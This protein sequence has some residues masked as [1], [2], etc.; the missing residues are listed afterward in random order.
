M[1][2]RLA[3]AEDQQRTTNHA[4][5]TTTLAALKRAEE[6][7]NKGD[8]DA[9]VSQAEKAAAVD[10][11]LAAPLLQK[12]S[13]DLKTMGWDALITADHHTAIN[14]L[15]QA[16][17]LNPADQNA[18]TKLDQARDYAAKW[19]LVETKIKEFDALMAQKDLVAHQVLI[20]AQN[21]ADNHGPGDSQQATPDMKRVRNDFDQGV[22]E[23]NK[24][25]AE[26]QA[27]HYLFQAGKF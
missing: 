12:F 2:A 4:A 5:Q 10:K 8:Y 14:R 21:I 1:E 25:I 3:R 18:R 23:Y 9:A 22:Q 15:E 16:V 20:D 17:R 19:P 27:L 7:W 13:R 24:F 26:K 6:L 11:D